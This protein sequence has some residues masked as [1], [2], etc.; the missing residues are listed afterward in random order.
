MES[1]L[2]LSVR[3][4]NVIAAP[5]S[6]V[7]LQACFAALSRKPRE[8]QLYGLMLSVEALSASGQKNLDHLPT[9]KASVLLRNVVKTL[10]Y[11]YRSSLKRNDVYK[12]LEVMYVGA[13]TRVFLENIQY[14]GVL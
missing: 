14:S 1:F 8:K 7:T 13:S 2:L 9:G 3:V 5:G 12:R 11:T 4:F 6:C 10:S